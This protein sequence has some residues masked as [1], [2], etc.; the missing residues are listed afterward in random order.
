MSDLFPYSK[1]FDEDIK[2]LL[3]SKA[4]VGT[5]NINDAMK[6]YA[7]AKSPEGIHYI[8]VKKTWEKLMLAAR[9]IASVQNPQ[10]ILVVSNRLYAQRAVIKFGRH[11]GAEAFATKWVPGTLTNYITKRFTEPRILIIADPINDYQALI[12]ASYMNIP[13]IAFC[14]LDCSLKNID[15]AIPCNNKGRESIATMF[16]L[17]A[18]EVKFL[19]GDLKRDEQWDEMIDLFMYRDINEKAAEKKGEEKADDESVEEQDKDEDA[20]EGAAEKFGNAKDDAED[21]DEDEDD[22]NWGAKKGET[23]Q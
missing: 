4:Y 1:T 10:D 22:G 3:A 19:R 6:E 9:V 16:Y 17:L 14:D 23:K 8:N 18:R 11:T 21:E 13:T 2:T 12:E 7:Y 20:E 15:I 5:K